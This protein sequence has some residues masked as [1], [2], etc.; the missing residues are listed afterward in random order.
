MVTGLATID[1]FVYYFDAAGNM[2]TGVVDVGGTP[3]LFDTD[4]KLLTLPVP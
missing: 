4:G 1:G 3:L 2:Q